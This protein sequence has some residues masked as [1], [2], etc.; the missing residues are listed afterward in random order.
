M[1]FLNSSFNVSAS[2]VDK[3]PQKVLFLRVNSPTSLTFELPVEHP[4]IR[5]RENISI[6]FQDI[7][8]AKAGGPCGRQMGLESQTKRWMRDYLENSKKIEIKRWREGKFFKVI[9][10]GKNLE[11]ELLQKICH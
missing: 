2:P 3:D 11:D 4:G 10:D 9:V 6:R 8:F 7:N 5:L 1:I